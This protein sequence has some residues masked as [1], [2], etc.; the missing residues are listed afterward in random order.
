MRELLECESR[1]LISDVVQ[2]WF[3]T[4]RR[5]FG[6]VVGDFVVERVADGYLGGDL[7]N[8]ETVAFEARAEDRDTRGFISITII[9]P[10][11]GLIA[12]WML[13]PP[14][15]TPTARM[16]PIATSRIRW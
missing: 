1:H 13:Q 5:L 8:R 15:S 16:M 6:D 11:A 3:E 10:S 14:V 4:G 2:R 9:R 7:G 12:N